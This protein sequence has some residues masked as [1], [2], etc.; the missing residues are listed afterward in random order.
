MTEFVMQMG[1]Q[2]HLIVS[3]I[4]IGLMTESRSIVAMTMIQ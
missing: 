3:E 2:I 1:E 4:A